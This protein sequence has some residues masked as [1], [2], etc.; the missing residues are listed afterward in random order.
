MLSEGHGVRLAPERCADCGAE[1][2]P[3]NVR[4]SGGHYAVK[5]HLSCGGQFAR[6]VLCNVCG[7]PTEGMATGDQL[8]GYTCF[9][10]ARGAS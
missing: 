3:E 8:T 2:T 4:W 7:R 5:M 9:A 10:C 6:A 1:P